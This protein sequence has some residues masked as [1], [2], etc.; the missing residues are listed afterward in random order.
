RRTEN[1]D[2]R[3]YVR[4]CRLPNMAIAGTQRRKRKVVTGTQGQSQDVTSVTE[5]QDV[6]LQ[7]PRRQGG[8]YTALPA[9][10]S[11]S[12]SRPPLGTAAARGRLMLFGP[13]GPG[14]MAA[15]EECD[16]TQSN[17]R[18]ITGCGCPAPCRSPGVIPSSSTCALPPRATS[19]PGPCRS[20]NSPSVP[21]WTA[22]ACSG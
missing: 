12:G 17:A 16:S 20:S 4:L 22:S 21:C 19:L 15:G 9:G 2:N 3:L 6:I 11:V 5:D 14:S 18:S 7:N 10:F 13:S 8:V 1:S